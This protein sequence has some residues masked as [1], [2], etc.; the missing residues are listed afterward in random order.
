MKG[1]RIT[2][3][4]AED[5]GTYMCEAEN[6]VGLITSSAV[7]KVR[8]KLTKFTCLTKNPFNAI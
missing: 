6:L 8:C 7:L 2:G 4:T 5:S 1:L 3:L